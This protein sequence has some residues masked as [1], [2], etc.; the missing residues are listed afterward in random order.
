M[1]PFQ[2]ASNDI[3]AMGWIKDGEKEKIPSYCPKPFAD[4]ILEC[5][6]LPD[7]RPTIDKIVKSV[8][9]AISELDPTEG[10]KSMEGDEIPGFILSPEEITPPRSG[11]KILPT[12]ASGK[13]SQTTTPPIV[14]DSTESIVLDSH[15]YSK[16]PIVLD[17]SNELKFTK[18]TQAYTDGHIHIM[19]EE[20]PQ[21]LDCFE[22]SSNEGYL[23]ADLALG[24]LFRNHMCDETKCKHYYTKV[25]SSIQ[26]F[27][28]KA[29]SGEVEVQ[30]ALGF[31]Y[32][33]GIGVEPSKEKAVHWYK[34]A[35]EK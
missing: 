7:K 25:A 20:Y 13:K 30:T 34:I 3:V 29:A 21:A 6:K 24:Y 4:L 35:A 23:P 5:W 11:E 22:K 19:K 26:W 16:S 17:D 2:D 8:E 18:R 28:N 10:E 9:T 12:T 31:C 14:I 32:F 15:D 1:T 33:H 27:E